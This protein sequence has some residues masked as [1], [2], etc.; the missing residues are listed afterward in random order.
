[1]RK[2]CLAFVFVLMAFVPF[3]QASPISPSCGSFGTLSAATFGGSGIPNTA[4]CMGTFGD[5]TLGLTVTP[6]FDNPPVV[7]D[8]AGTFT[9]MAGGDVTHGKPG[10][11]LANFDFYMTGASKYRLFYDLDPG[12]G[13]DLADLGVVNFGAGTNQDS[14][15]QGFGFLRTG[16]AGVV[17]PPSYALAFNPAAFGEYGL[18]LQGLNPDDKILGEVSILLDTTPDGTPVP[19]PGS[20]MLLGSGLFAAASAARR[21]FL[22]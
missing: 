19:E 3:V 5:V 15:N 12:V 22:V 13:T 18:L 8:G 14:W 11:A 1:M 20:L 7:N 21:R 17:T 2:T 9:D 16:V 4:V 10:Y 6:R